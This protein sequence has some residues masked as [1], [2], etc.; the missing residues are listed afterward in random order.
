MKKAL[1]L[2][3]IFFL[4][5]LIG[6]G[7]GTLFYSIYL[8]SLNH[9]VGTNTTFFSKDKL[10][11]AFFLAGQVMTLLIGYLLI[12]YR[13]RHSGGILQLLVFII[14]Q[15]FCWGFLFPFLFQIEDIYLT[16][17]QDEITFEDKSYP[18][19]KGFFRE[20]DNVVYYFMDDLKTSYPYGEESTNAVRINTR[21]N[22]KIGLTEVRTPRFLEISQKAKPYKDILVKNTFAQEESS[23]L[24]FI[25]TL[26]NLA[27][28]NYHEGWT[29]WLGF[30]S[31]GFALACVYALSGISDWR[32]ITFSIDTVITAVLLFWNYI[33]TTPAMNA[34]K[35][36]KIAKI[37]FE[38]LNKY[39]NNQFL[40]LTNIL[41]GLV[42]IVIGIILHF[43]KKHKNQDI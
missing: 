32:L 21:E 12:S 40:I 36:M 26:V 31:L 19:T 23:H 39:I 42:M 35:S 28:K 37:G 22:G 38:P 33:Y 27:K 16:K 6:T 24:Y 13:I 11:L 34:F 1:K 10:I 3:F 2:F 14:T 9:I 43:V 5:F 29:F 20:S 18:L 30:A 7:L 25:C 41:A 8:C 4:F 17:H 15:V